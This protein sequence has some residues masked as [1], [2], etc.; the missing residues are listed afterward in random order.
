MG[1]DDAVKVFKDLRARWLVPMHYGSFQLS[2]EEMDEPPRWLLE[3]AEQNGISKSVRI[4]EE[5]V[6]EVF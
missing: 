2:F 5:G 3:L 4:L 6:P 1:P